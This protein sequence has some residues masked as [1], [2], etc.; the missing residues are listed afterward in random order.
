MPRRGSILLAVMVVITL[1]ALV[2]TTALYRAD[3]QRGS[4]MT[5]MEHAQ[6]RAL[7]WSGVQGAMSELA[8]QRAVLMQGGVPTLTPAWDLYTGT[9]RGSVRLAPLGPSGTVAVSEGGKLDL[10]SVDAAML[11]RLVGVGDSLAGKIIGARG[12]GFGSP[13]E[14]ANVEGV[15]ADALYGSAAAGGQ[16]DNTG[17]EAPG[18]EDESTSPLLSL[19]TVFSFDPNTTIGVGPHA[20]GTELARINVSGGWT[21]GLD[22]NLK[23]RMSEAAAAALQTVLKAAKPAH[24]SDIVSGLRNT[25][26]PVDLWAEALGGVTTSDDAYRRGH[27]DMNTASAEVLACVPGIDRAA[28]DRI[29]EARAGVDSQS[30]QS[31]T[32]PLKQGILTEDQFQLAADWITTRSLQWRVRVEARLARGDDT[33]TSQPE[34]EPGPPGIVWEAVIDVSGARARVAY[35]RDVT[36]LGALA[37]RARM[38]ASGNPTAKPEAPLDEQGL[39]TPQPSTG[40]KKDRLRIDSDLH[41]EGMKGSG[42]LQMD[43]ALKLHGDSSPGDSALRDTGG[44]DASESGGASQP[45]AAPSVVTKDRRIGRWRAPSKE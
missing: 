34:T 19:A 41:F 24:G 13:E 15:S 26:T 5:E 27:V 32:W 35:L 43:T 11:A 2:G 44:P 14:L 20:S 3:A 7:A 8:G 23:D 31:V 22:A 18:Q 45:G 12:G 21:D 10:N 16:A 38:D 1:A 28:A 39:S 25:K 40:P 37:Q 17:A 4:A 33:P 36:Y 6:L 30:R 29:V 42:R 9:V